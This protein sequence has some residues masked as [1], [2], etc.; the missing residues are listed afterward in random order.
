MQKNTKIGRP[1]SFD[2]ECILEKSM[3]A[4]WKYGFSGANYDVLEQATGL[5]RQSLVYAF[6]DKRTLFLKSLSHYFSTRVNDV[7]TILE[8]EGSGLA[9][10]RCV[11][12]TW[13]ATA[14]DE[15]KRGCLIVN[16]SGQFGTSDKEIAAIVNRAVDALRNAF[17]AAFKSAQVSGEATVKVLPENLA[18]LT[19]AAGN[20]ALLHV[21]S[22]ENTEYIKQ[23]LDSI[24]AIVSVELSE[25]K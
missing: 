8:R 7:V 24:L 13:L 23:V 14:I 22:D 16:T 9:N 2:E 18:R 11:F 1:R 21:H 20:G 3:S 5:K 17:S 6:G 25:V 10:I 19:V 12:D 15:T 4:F